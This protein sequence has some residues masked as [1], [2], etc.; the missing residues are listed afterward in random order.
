[1]LKW[2]SRLPLYNTAYIEKWRI[3]G[4]RRR[5]RKWKRSPC[6]LRASAL[7]SRPTRTGPQ[8]SQRSGVRSPQGLFPSYSQGLQRVI[9]LLPF[10]LVGF[11]VAATTQ[12]V[13][14]TQ[15]LQCGWTQHTQWDSENQRVASYCFPWWPVNHPHSL[16]TP[17]DFGAGLWWPSGLLK[18]LKSPV[19][20]D[21]WSNHTSA[22]DTMERRT[23][24]KWVFC[25][26]VQCDVCLDFWTLCIYVGCKPVR[27]LPTG[28]F[29]KRVWV[30]GRGRRMEDWK[31]PGRW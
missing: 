17:V 3:N 8:P 25:C 4:S 12:E 5:D 30:A 7:G 13:S 16:V 14:V 15:S 19:L 22:G 11:T 28:L 26:V 6:E 1:M 23:L 24:F 29:W 27:G 9:S 2:F 10:L 18:C 21:P 31:A 20:P